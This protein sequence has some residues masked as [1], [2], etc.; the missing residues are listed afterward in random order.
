MNAN[1]YSANYKVEFGV[2]VVEYGGG[3]FTYEVYPNC[4][5]SWLRTGLSVNQFYT[6][7]I[8]LLGPQVLPSGQSIEAQ[9]DDPWSFGFQDFAYVPALTFKTQFLF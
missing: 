2:D 9:A 7:K 1:S 5:H 4:T 8:V 6:V 3:S